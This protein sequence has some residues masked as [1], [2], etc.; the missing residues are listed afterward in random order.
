MSDAPGDARVAVIVPAYNER[1]AIAGVI[2]AIHAHDAALEI[3]VV[4]DGSTDDTAA[5][6]RATGEAVVL[7]LPVNLGIGGAVQTGFMYAAQ[8]GHAIAIQID[9]DGQHNPWEVD[10]LLAPILAGEA[11]VTIGSRFCE[12]RA[13]FKST[14]ARRLGIRIFEATSALLIR[15]RVTDCTSGFRAY[16]R[17]AI[18]FLA[19]RYPQDYPEPEAVI[20]LGINGFR[21]REVSVTMSARKGGRSSISGLRTL[22][23]MIKVLLAVFVVALRGKDK[24]RRPCR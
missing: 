15:Q 7:D 19:A 9:G 18:E 5:V 14:F 17:R 6:A 20:L 2:G 8:Q 16:N 3:V 13:G 4:N 12:E 10:R 11:D 23:Y 1:E 22:Y 21:I 24:E